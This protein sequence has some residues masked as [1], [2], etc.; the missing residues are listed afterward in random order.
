MTH[1]PDGRVV[2]IV[3]ATGS[4]KTSY[5]RQA[6]AGARRLLVWDV[7]HTLA[8]AMD[9]QPVRSRRA[10]LDLLALHMLKKPAR[11]AY[12][13]PVASPDEFDF[14]AGC[15]FAWCGAAPAAILAEELADVT[16]PGKAPPEWGKLL[17]RGRARGALVYAITQRI[18]ECDTTA[19]GLA[20]ELICFRLDRPGDRAKMAEFMD[21]P[22][23]DI[24]RLRTAGGRA[25]YLQRDRRSGKLHKKTLQLPG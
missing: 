15:A 18:T 11:I 2:L 12:Q 7:E 8:R 14:F 10:L 1:R 19:T 6:L 22:A 25:E 23:A 9:C 17:R 13:P 3:G 4:G 5:A 21:V 20:A 16:R 24:G